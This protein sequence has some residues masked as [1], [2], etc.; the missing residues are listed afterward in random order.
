MRYISAFL[1]FT[2]FAL[3]Q[4]ALPSVASAAPVTLA[5]VAIS[6]EFQ[7]TLDEDL[8]AREGDVLRDATARMVSAALARHGATLSDSAPLVVEIV[9][10][11]ADPNRPTFEQLGASPGLDAFRSISVGGAELRGTLRAADGHIVSEVNHRRYNNS[12]V[13]LTG[14]ESTWTDARR[15]IR[16]FAEKIADAYVANAR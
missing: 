15:A 8:G 10:V 13:D 16:Q 7:T 5:P 4:A 6:A 2:A 14:G 9:I 11:D 1:G 12:L 3:A